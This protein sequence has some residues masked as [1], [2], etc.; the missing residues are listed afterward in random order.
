MQVAYPA[1]AVQSAICLRDVRV[2]VTGTEHV[3]P[4]WVSSSYHGT[5]SVV[6]TSARV[7]LTTAPSQDC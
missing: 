7:R 2:D 5:E 6:H 3:D 1:P 4:K